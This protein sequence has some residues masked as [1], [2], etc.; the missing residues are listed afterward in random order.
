MSEL[1]LMRKVQG[2]QATV[3]AMKPKEE[4]KEG[5]S[6]CAASTKERLKTGKIEKCL[7]VW[8]LEIPWWF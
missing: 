3:G 5:G 7:L 1:G 8:P 2:N 4:F 6:N